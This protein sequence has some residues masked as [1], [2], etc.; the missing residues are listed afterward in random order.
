MIVQI[1]LRARIAVSSVERNISA[2]PL[3]VLDYNGPN[4]LNY[5]HMMTDCR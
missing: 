1:Q 4:D 3:L 5:I 2:S